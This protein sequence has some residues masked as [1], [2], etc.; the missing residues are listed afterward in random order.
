MDGLGNTGAWLAGIAPGK[1][2]DFAAEAGALDAAELR[3]YVTGKLIALLSCL[4]H[5]PRRRARDDLAEMFCKRVA[6]KLKNAKDELEEIRKQQQA[7]VERMIGTY[8]T[9]LERINPAD[10]VQR[11]PEGVPVPFPA[12]KKARRKAARALASKRVAAL[13]LAQKAVP[14]ARG[15]SRRSSPTSRRWPR[16][17][18]T[19]TRYWSPAST[20]GTGRRCSIWWA[21]WSSRRSV[22]SGGSWTRWRTRGPTR[23]RPASTSVSCTRGSRWTSASPRRTGSGPSATGASPAR[24]TA[25]ALRRWCSPTWLSICGPAM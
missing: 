18:A 2:A 22:R 14:R 10:L 5:A 23:A 6:A 24:W 12:G 25:G 8:R 7:L 11:G 3:D 19:T 16:T 21:R 13:A 9:V 17:T 4:V 20:S 1:I 15:R